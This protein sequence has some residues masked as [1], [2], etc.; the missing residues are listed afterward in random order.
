[1]EP[2]YKEENIDTLFTDVSEQESIQDYYTKQIIMGLRTYGH[3]KIDV[4]L[5]RTVDYDI[6]NK[7]YLT[8]IAMPFCEHLNDIST[9]KKDEEGKP[10]TTEADNR[11]L[12]M[13]CVNDVGMVLFTGGLM[14]YAIL[15]DD[16]ELVEHL[17]ELGASVEFNEKGSDLSRE[18]INSSEMTQL[19]SKLREKE[20]TKK[21]N[22]PKRRIRN[23]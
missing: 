15:K 13:I 10:Y 21:S 14:Q 3:D 18:Y 2:I 1:M 16:L 23:K 7:I 22:K 5:D 6:N 4:L 12:G 17:A 11:F 19:V 20:E 9:V 8:D